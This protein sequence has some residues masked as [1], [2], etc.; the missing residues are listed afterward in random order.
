MKTN[1]LINHSR[2]LSIFNLRSTLWLLNILCF[3]VSVTPLIA[4]QDPF[5]IFLKKRN[6]IVF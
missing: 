2:P 3:F 4:Q 6:N 1:S 5:S